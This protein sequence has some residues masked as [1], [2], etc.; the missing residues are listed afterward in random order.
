MNYLTDSVVLAACTTGYATYNYTDTQ[1]CL[2]YVSEPA[3]YQEAAQYCQ[4]EGGDLIKLDSKLKYDIM[5]DYL[6]RPQIEYTL[7]CDTCIILCV[8]LCFS[9]F[10]T[11]AL[12]PN[13]ILL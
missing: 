13:V 11:Y 2:K 5:K 6:G 4:A 10:K 3:S 8:L 12:V 1:I 7:K 9:L